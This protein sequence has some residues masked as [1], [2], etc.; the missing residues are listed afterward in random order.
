MDLDTSNLEAAS[1]SKVLSSHLYNYTTKKCLYFKHLTI[2]HHINYVQKW[3]IRFYAV[4]LWFD[5]GTW[6]AILWYK[7]LR[8]KFVYVVGLVS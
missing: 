1:A 4:L 3:P 7:Y 2:L 6:S 8:N 5:V